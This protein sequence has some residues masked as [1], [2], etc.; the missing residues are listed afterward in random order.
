MKGG[1]V[2]FRH[3]EQSRFVSVALSII[4]IGA[5]SSWKASSAQEEISSTEPLTLSRA[6]EIALRSNPLTRVTAGGR[7]IAEAE[8]REAKAGRWP[9]LQ[10]T[11]NFT[12]SNNPVFVFGSL[13]EQGRFG[14]NNFDITSLNHPASLSNFRSA[15]MLRVPIFDQKQTETRVT[16]AR[17]RRAQAVL[18]GDLVEQ[19]LRFEVVRS[20]FGLLSAQARLGVADEAVKTAEADVKRARDMFEGG[21]VV[22]SDFLAAEVQLSQ[23]RQQRIQAIGELQTTIAALN[24]ALGLPV[25]TPQKLSGQLT[26]RDFKVET[27]DALSRQA[28]QDRPDYRRAIL[29]ARAGAVRLRGASN[30]RLPRAEAFV[31][32][33]ASTRYLSSGSGDYAAGIN[34][35]FNIF[36]AGR[37][38]R[39]D[40]A[41]AAESISRAETEHLANQ[42]RL[43]VVRAYQQY[44]TARGRLAV[45]AQAA[46]QATESLRIVQERYHAGIT[47]ITELLRAETALVLAR[48]AVLDARYDHYVGYARVLLA[49]GRLKDVVPFSS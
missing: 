19:Q 29:S 5:S 37:K 16:D 45:L 26:E 25:D 49:T 34:L 47:T 14:P 27:I 17:I 21:L 12:R 7:E 15:L 8:I 24:T 46:A 20:Y 2:R 42:V 43:E 1:R 22:R 38:A 4:L 23:F 35:S 40:A 28:L 3:S 31:T 9:L 6:V 33:G 30:E 41:R 13:L 39:I 44:V 18:Q 36:D 10:A 48:S 11:E 32:V